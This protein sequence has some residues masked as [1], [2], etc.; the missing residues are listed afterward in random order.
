[1]DINR[2]KT[3]EEKYKAK[4]FW[5]L[6]GK[7]DKEQLKKQILLMKEMGFGGAFLHSR[8][9]LVTEYLGKEWFDCLDFC[10]QVLKEN[11]MEAWLYDEDRWPSGTCGGQVTARKEFCAKFMLYREI[12]SDESYV[13]SENFLCLFAVK[14]DEQGKH[15]RKYRQV[16]GPFEKQSD[17]KILEFYYDYMKGD[18]FY[19]GNSY[20]DVMNLDATKYF[21]QLTHEKYKEVLGDKF[22]KEIIGVFTDEPNR[23]PILQGFTHYGEN[24]V[25]EIPYTFLLFD[26]F[27]EKKGYDLKESLPV[28]WFGKEDEPFAKEMYDL[29]DVLNDLFIENYAVP[30][31]AWCKENKLLVTGHILHEDNLA[32]QTI[33]CGSVM[34]Y[35]EYMDYPGVD[36]LSAHNNAYTVPALVSSVAKQLNKEF[37]LDELYGCSGWDMNLSDYKRMGDWQSAGG[38]TFR[39]PHLSWYTMKGESKRDCPASILHQSAWCK[40]YALVEDYFSRLTYLIH[41]GEDL[42]D[43]AIINP[44][45][46]IW[47]LVNKYTFDKV[48]F[49]P[50]DNEI[51]KKIETEYLGLYKILTE[52]GRSADYIDED[53]FSKYGEVKDNAF[54]CGQKRYK[55]IILNGNLTLRSTTFKA[56]K[57]FLSEGGK[58]TLIG[59]YPQYLDGEK[60]DFVKELERVQK[61]DFTESQILQNIQNGNLTVDKNGIIVKQTS[62][63]DGLFNFILNVEKQEKKVQIKIATDLKPYLINLREGVVEELEY[64]NKNGVITIDTILSEYQE[65][66]V[67]CTNR[68]VDTKKKKTVKYQPV[69]APTDYSLSL[70]EGNMLVLDKAKCYI[71][72]E[73]VLEDY[74]LQIDDALR[75][76]FGLEKRNHV[77]IQPWFKAKYALDRKE[78]FCDLVL[79]YNFNV[80]GEIKDLSL[81]TEEIYGIKG[82]FLNGK[83]I[84]LSSYTLTE[85]DS[86]FRLF[87]VKKELI[88]EGLNTLQI[89]TDYYEKTNLESIF[90]VGNIAVSVEDK[91]DGI[92]ALP[93]TIKIGDLCKQGLPYFGGKLL[94]T[95]DLPNGEYKAE[96]ESLDCALCKINDVSV[97]FAPY[98]CEFSVTD[99]KIKIELT[100]NRNNSFGVTILD[101]RRQGIKEQG[102]L[103][104]IKLLKAV[105]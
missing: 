31:Q 13:Q 40:D 98:Q 93:E 18:S 50:F 20:V 14:F 74:V 7:L 9:G 12:D 21:I 36:N 84:D 59:N 66:A 42:T 22:G 34:R 6:N 27:K 96:M 88:K 8:A 15:I 80:L 64:A 77:M 47:G 104:G 37:V 103:K 62:Y 82:V 32:V 26:K 57:K 48:W 73:F 89:I 54:I 105:K 1:M 5:S 79:E 3:I 39:C 10:I 100:M 71:D 4:P 30:Y 19:N 29:I 51:C 53:I 17:E 44:I 55:H 76:R 85:I 65:F 72:G 56:I 41:N 35:F 23:G 58:V 52:N 24:T 97:A 69:R 78:K 28:L 49:G 63:D 101:G 45:E 83:E 94:L 68:K 75:K 43:V 2:I 81:M 67:Y 86:C 33:M 70:Q 91:M 95:A 61:I 102:L 46:S 92:K 90:I 16:K 60:Y 99:N 25:N 87:E 38:I 11:G